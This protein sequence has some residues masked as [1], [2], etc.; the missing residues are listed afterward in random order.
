MFS[1]DSGQ[2]QNEDCELAVCVWTAVIW[3]WSSFPYT[4]Y[5][6]TSGKFKINFYFYL[7]LLEG[8]LYMK[9]LVEYNKGT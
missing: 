4:V 3:K 5:T 7:I 8:L 6:L 1:W 9:Q 2:N